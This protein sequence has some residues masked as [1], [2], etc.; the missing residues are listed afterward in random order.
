MSGYDIESKTNPTESEPEKRVKT[1]SPMPLGILLGV[2]L[3]VLMSTLVVIPLI[4]VGGFLL[5]YG[6]GIAGLVTEWFFP[7]EVNRIAFIDPQGHLGTIS[8]DGSDLRILAGG[9]RA[10][11]FPAWSPSGPELAVIGDDTQGGG[12]FLTFDQPE[13]KMRQVYK[14]PEQRP[15]YQYWSPDGTYIS[16]IAGHREGLGLHVVP[17]GLSG[18]RR[19]V[20][21]GE[22]PFFW[23][24][25]P[26]EDQVLIHTGFTGLSDAEPR[27]AF[28]PIDAEM[29]GKEVDARGHFQTP[30]VSVDGQYYAFGRGDLV[31]GKFL[32]VRD[33][34]SDQ[35]TWMQ[36][37][38]GVVAMGWNPTQ[39]QLAFISPETSRPTFYG[40]LRLVDMRTKEPK[41]LVDDGVL[42]FFWSPDG[43][44]IA[45]L[46]LDGIDEQPPL[47]YVYL[48]LWVVDIEGGEPR[49][50]MTF[51]PTDLFVN[52]LMP[53]FE[54]YAQS[55]KIWSPESDALVLPMQDEDSN[56]HIVVVPV[57]GSEPVVLTEGEIAFWSHR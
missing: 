33:S 54:T 11:K 24:W 1:R 44:S 26:N 52:E 49:F 48:N 39:S 18:G 17:V 2:M 3:G 53:F 50:L 12:L 55:H 30:A 40:P 56:S 19:V 20:A 36:P 37:H 7:G 28:V 38:K 51:Q 45:Y 29:E 14:H 34:E 41:R 16:F 9:D 42:A 47:V 32:V 25:L 15:I 27:L 23:H 10:Y 5:Q 43:R 21:T 35:T 8:P 31:G 46:T 6:D 22:A 4:V 13:N 57:D